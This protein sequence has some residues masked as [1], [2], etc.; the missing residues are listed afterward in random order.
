MSS[1][2]PSC[3]AKKDLRLTRAG[4]YSINQ[5]MFDILTLILFGIV[6]YFVRKHGYSA[7]AM[8]IGFILSI[9]IIFSLSFK[10]A[11]SPI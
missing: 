7:G 2:P 4:A 3:K 8:I 11:D 9:V 1:I 5:N 10:A 6:G